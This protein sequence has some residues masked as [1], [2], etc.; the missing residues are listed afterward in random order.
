MLYS[1]ETTDYLSRAK[2]YLK[3]HGLSNNIENPQTIQEKLMWLNIYEPDIMKTKCADKLL[4]HEYS[5]DILGK[6]ICIPV[7]KVYNETS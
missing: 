2:N 7:I 1:I 4:L 6:D 3:A 5:K